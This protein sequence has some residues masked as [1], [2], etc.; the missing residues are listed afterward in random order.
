MST[1]IQKVFYL[2]RKNKNCQKK[3][4]MKF[5][6]ILMPCDIDD[7]T[8]KKEVFQVQVYLK[9][10][11]QYCFRVA[12]GCM[13]VGGKPPTMTQRGRLPWPLLLLAW[14]GLAPWSP[15]NRYSAATAAANF[16]LHKYGYTETRVI[17]YNSSEKRRRKS[18]NFRG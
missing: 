1:W 13:D 11:G 5:E 17:D 12:L 10:K 8:T 9:F 3:C 6:T 2:I 16:Y 4:K 18:G 14:F 15:G 7:T